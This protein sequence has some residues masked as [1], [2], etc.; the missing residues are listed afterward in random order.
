M[1]KVEANLYN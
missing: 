1:Y